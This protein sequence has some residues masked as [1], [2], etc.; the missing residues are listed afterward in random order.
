MLR[1]TAFVPPS[2]LEPLLNASVVAGATARICV[3]FGAR[4]PSTCR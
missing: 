4:R 2:I 1:V 3:A